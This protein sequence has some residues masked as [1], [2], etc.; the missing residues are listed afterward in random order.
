M[1][2]P[3]VYRAA[4]LPAVLAV[5]LAMFSLESRPRPLPQ[6]LAADVLFDGRQAAITANGI[7]DRAPDRRAGTRGNR[8]TAELVAET[9]TRARLRRWSATRSAARAATWS[10]W[11]GRR[12]GRRR[13]QVVVVA[14]RD[15][16]GPPDRA[17]SAADTAALMELARVFE[18]RSSERTLVLASVDGGRLGQVGA[19]RLAGRLKASDEEVAAVL[20]VSGPGHSQLRAAAGGLVGRHLARGHRTGAHRRRGCPAGAGHEA[21]RRRR[22]PVSSAGSPSRSG[23]GGQGVFLDAGFDSLRFSGSGE[24]EPGGGRAPRPG[25]SGRPGSCRAA[26]AQQPR[27]LRGARARAA[28][29]RDRRQPGASRAGWSP[30]WR[31]ALLLP[32]V[33]ASVDAFARARRRREPVLPGC[34]ASGWWRPR[35]PAGLL[36][37]RFLTLAGATPGAPQ[38][39]VDPSALPLDGPAAIVLAAVVLVT[40]GLL[41]VVEPVLRAAG[42]RPRPAPRAPPRWCCAAPCLVLWVLDPYAALLA[43]PALHLWVLAC[44]SSPAPG[45]AFA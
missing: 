2:E 39:A 32:A 28:L 4:F 42:I 15:A 5:V 1:I 11:S 21:S 44:C 3:R 37:T 14:A 12:P 7:A 18:G 40:A 29:L 43:V 10:T 23:S 13:E 8:A 33:V 24:L 30:C 35:W 20:V 34:A 22:W 17:G 26:H 31:C 36:L 9:F 41:Y 25:P 16:P 27:R 6:G 19:R 45:A 38:A